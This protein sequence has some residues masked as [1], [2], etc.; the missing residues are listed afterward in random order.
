[1]AIAQFLEIYQAR[2][3]LIAPLSNKYP[4]RNGKGPGQL[5][6]AFDRLAQYASGYLFEF[7][8]RRISPIRDDYVN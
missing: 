3:V 6:Q 4:R 2:Q 5:D 1:V 8:R 7:L